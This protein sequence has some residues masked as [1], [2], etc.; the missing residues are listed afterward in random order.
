MGFALCVLTAASLEIWNGL[1]LRNRI[2]IVRSTQP[3][4]PYSFLPVPKMHIGT[5]QFADVSP[6][7]L[8]GCAGYFHTFRITSRL[9]VTW[10]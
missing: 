8:S 3:T 4:K 5:S 2:G 9:S 1:L 6:H 7:R 10:G